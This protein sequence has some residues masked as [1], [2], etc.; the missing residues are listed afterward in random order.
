MKTA[1]T[2]IA[3]IGPATAATLNEHRIRS[4]SSLA[5][6]SVERIAAI[7]G[8]SESRAS[9][10]IAAAGELLAGSGT[11]RPTKKKALN[12]GKREEPESGDVVKGKAK[13]KGKGKGKGKDKKKNKKKRKDK[14][15][16]KGKKK[17]KGKKKKK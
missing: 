11:K 4:L 3:G 5:N 9:R 16:N 8:F 17:G 1:I 2:D 7:P 14:K 13:G 12:P 15:K 6:A 10:V